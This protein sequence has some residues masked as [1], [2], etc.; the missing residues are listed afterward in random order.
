MPDV[1]RTS[2]HGS[3]RRRESEDE[4]RAQAQPRR[5]WA[6][7]LAL[8]YPKPISHLSDNIN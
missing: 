7:D 1:A 2:G 4:H 8:G 6:S 5:G 3:L